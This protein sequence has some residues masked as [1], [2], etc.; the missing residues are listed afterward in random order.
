MSPEPVTQ[1]LPYIRAVNEALRWALRQYPEA[2]VFGEDVAIPGGPFGATRGLLEE[3]GERVFDT[4][5]SESAMVGAAIGAAMR[6]RRPILEIMWIDFTQVAMDQLVNQ[7]PNVHYV[8]QGRFRLPLTIRTQMGFTPGSCAQHSACLEAFF[9]HVPGIRVGLPASPQDAY[10]MLRSAI[11]SDIPV[12]IIESRALYPEKGPVVLGG[13][14]APIGGAQVLRQGS[15]VT[16][17]SWSRM[18]REAAAAAQLLAQRGTSAEVIDLRWLSPL[19]FDTVMQSLGRTGRLVVAHEANVTGGFGAEIAARAA[20]Q[21][22]WMLDGPVLRLG[23]PD[24][25][26]PA[27]PSLQEALIPNAQT[28][29]AAVEEALAGEHRPGVHARRSG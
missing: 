19:D 11:A 13:P 2:L 7:L 8:S 22:F 6:G 5:I 28:I 27:A 14:V 17:V 26:I 18:V 9:A 4:P 23:A 12:L 3:F 15:D 1:E 29:A 16:I 25:R 20:E 21:G 10:D 24:T